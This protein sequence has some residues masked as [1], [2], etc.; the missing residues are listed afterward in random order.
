MAQ[1]RLLVPASRQGM[2]HFK[3]QVMSQMLDRPI[4]NPND[5]KIEVAKKLGIP[6]KKEDNG[7]L[8]AKDAGKIGGVIGGQ[9]VKEMVRFAQSS[10]LHRP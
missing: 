10:L 2:E 8:K 6:L 3:V 7:D 5:V 9:M 1:D 4:S